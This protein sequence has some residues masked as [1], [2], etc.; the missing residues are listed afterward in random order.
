MTLIVQSIEQG[1]AGSDSENGNI[2]LRSN[3]DDTQETTNIDASALGEKILENCN[4]ED[5]ETDCKNF[6]EISNSW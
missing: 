1:G 6:V 2:V 5:T 3:V 4:A